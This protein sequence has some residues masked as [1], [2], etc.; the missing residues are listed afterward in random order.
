MGANGHAF[1]AQGDACGGQCFNLIIRFNDLAHEG[2]Y[3]LL[4][5]LGGYH[6]VK[7]YNNDIVDFN[8]PNFDATDGFAQSSVNG[9]EINNLFYYP[10]SVTLNT[11]VVYP[12]SLMGFTAGSNLAY[13][14]GSCAFYSRNYG[15][16]S[17]TA[18][19]S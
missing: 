14:T 1:L 19:A 2:S 5:Q 9:A 18:D 10:R 8:I 3:D 13:C 15:S 6:D 17:F 11:Y 7:S 12:D 16:G 4:D